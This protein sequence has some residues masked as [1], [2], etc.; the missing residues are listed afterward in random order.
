[1]LD[2]SEDKLNW[3]DAKE[4]LLDLRLWVHYFAYLCLGVGVS[5]MSLFAPTI[6]AGLG[7]KDL[8]AQLFTVPPYAAAYVV[9]LAAGIFSD[10]KKMRGVV[11]GTSFTIGAVAFIVQG[12]FSSPCY[13]Y[14]RKNEVILTAFLATLPNQSYGVR[15][16]MLII[17]TSGVFAGLP[18]LCAWV[19]DNVHSTTAGSIA[20]GLNIAFTGPG[21]IIGVWIYRAQDAPFYTLG[22]A[23]NAGFL[24]LGAILS[25][26]LAWHY[27]RLNRKLKGTTE[28]R[29]IA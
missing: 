19:S 29:W 14:S 26:G 8:R 17:A 5:S 20:S 3:A 10:R 23:V 1:M 25:F 7:Y 27:N 21:Q 6:V 2:D 4:T 22:H 13:H 15:Y 9:T 12:R 28:K 16:A 11:A 24:V 18:S